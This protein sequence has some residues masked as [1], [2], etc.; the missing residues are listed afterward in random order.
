MNIPVALLPVMESDLA[1][2][3]AMRALGVDYGNLR[4][5]GVS[6]FDYARMQADD[7]L[8]NALGSRKTAL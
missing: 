2:I 3:R 5:R 4:Y 6:A 1:A 8:L 7:A